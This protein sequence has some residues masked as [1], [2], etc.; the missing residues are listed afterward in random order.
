MSTLLGF[1]AAL[2]RL[3]ASLNRLATVADHACDHIEGKL[4]PAAVE[5]LPAPE[6]KPARKVK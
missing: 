5:A 6:E 3:A 1:F 2:Q 4:P